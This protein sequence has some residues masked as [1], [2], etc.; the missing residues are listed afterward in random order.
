MTIERLF[1]EPG[2]KASFQQVT[3][4]AFHSK[5][6]GIIV[7]PLF[8]F[9]SLPFFKVMT[10]SKIPF[11]LVN[12]FIAEAKPLCFIGQDSFKSGRL[13]AE[14][15]TLGNEVESTYT[16]L[17]IDE[18]LTNSVHLMEKEKGFRNYFETDLYDKRILVK[19][20][21][22]PAPAH[23]LFE[24]ELDNILAAPNL[25]GIFVSN[26]K[27]HVIAQQ[28]EKRKSK[29]R[30]IGYDLLKENIHYLNKGVIQ[31]IIHQ[32][33]KRQAKLGVRTL[34]NYLLFSKN[35]QPL[36]LFPLEVITKNNL[37]S[38]QL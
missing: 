13:A 9:A 18:D 32:N 25:K 38:Y 20:Y 14:L 8:Y 12:T 5:P 34:A 4:K 2:K 10:E 17:H 28:L 30:L 24:K 1:Y 29:V 7:A 11:V 31:F 21:T 26:S 3:L 19:S 22:L 23:L 6:D 16:I 37:D 27:T 15:L 33:P 36:N 35:P